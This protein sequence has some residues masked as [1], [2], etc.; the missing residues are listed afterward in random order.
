MI[1]KIDYARRMVENFHDYFFPKNC[2]NC[3][4]EGSWLCGSCKN[5]LFFIE[6]RTCPFCEKSTDLFFVCEECQNKAQI[7]KVFSLFKYSDFLAQ[8]LIKSFKYRFLEGVIDDMEPLMR[9]FLYKYRELIYV[10]NDSV[11][12]PVPL[13]WHKKCLR[14]F[15]QAELIAKSIGGILNIEVKTNLVIKKNITRNQAEIS[16]KKRRENIKDAFKI[17]SYIPKNII[18]VDDVI[19]TG[20]TI[21]EIARILSS[22][23]AENIQVITLARG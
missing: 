6:N 20:S 10:K 8:E 1:G 21:A 14:G 5:S 11:I 3:K 18:I 13:Y 19:T 7:S 12:M 15:N 17:N 9:K 22:A 16:P 2:L 23:G 4:K